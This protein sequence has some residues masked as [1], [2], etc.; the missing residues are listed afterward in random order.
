VGG[1]EVDKLEEVPGMWISGQ[2]GGGDLVAVL[3]RGHDVRV[4][5]EPR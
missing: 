5:H 1:S 2:A 3:G 4:T